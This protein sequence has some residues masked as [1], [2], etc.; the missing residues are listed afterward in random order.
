M[1]IGNPHT[2]FIIKR[3]SLRGSPVLVDLVS[4]DSISGPYVMSPFLSSINAGD[5]RAVAQFL[6]H[7]EYYP[8]LC[9][10]GTE[11]AYLDGLRNH[12]D[13]MEEIVKCGIVYVLAQ[14]LGMPQLQALAF[15]KFKALQ[16]H[17]AYQF[18]VVTGL[19]FGSGSA[20][21]GQMYDF[22][23]DYLAVSINSLQMYERC[24]SL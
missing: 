17:P 12:E 13:G 6:E 9:G 1:Y 2:I 3:N 15:S 19:L 7:G 18:L 11:Y 8:R 4:F 16:P 10:A 5:F 23:V 21:E 22:A 20:C 24:S 14:K